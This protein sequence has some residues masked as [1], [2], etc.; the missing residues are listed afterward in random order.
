M[1]CAGIS[2]YN[3]KRAKFSLRMKSKVKELVFLC[4]IMGYITYIYIYIYIYIHIYIYTIGLYNI[5]IFIYIYIYIYIYL[6]KTRMDSN[7]CNRKA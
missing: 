2:A 3:V 1:R 6:E 4:L 7:I 5:Y